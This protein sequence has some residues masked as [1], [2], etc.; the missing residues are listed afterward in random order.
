M[1]QKASP[2]LYAKLESLQDGETVDVNIFLLNKPVLEPAAENLADGGLPLDPVTAMQAA[3]SVNQR[4]LVSFLTGPQDDFVSLNENV[5]TPTAIVKDTYWI[6]N[7]VT[8]E[9]D[10]ET[11]EAI[12][13]REDVDYVELRSNARLQDMLDASMMDGGLSFDGDVSPANQASPPTA[14]TPQPSATIERIGAPLMWKEGLRGEGIIVAVIDSGVNYHHPDLKSHMWD[15]GDEFPNHGFDMVTSDNNPF[16]D[17]A[18]FNG[19]GTAC[20]GIIAGDGTSGE[21]TGVAPKATLMAIRIK[22]EETALKGLEQALEHHPHVISM[23]F[24]KKHVTLID[25]TP[26]PSETEPDSLKWRK[27]CESIFNAGIL[28]ANSAGNQG[29]SPFHK[30][31]RNIGSPPDCPPPKLHLLQSLKGGVSSVISCGAAT[32]NDSLDGWSSNG[33]VA[34]NSTP[35]SDY[36]F[37]DNGNRGLMKPD[38]CAPGPGSRSCN[39]RFNG[40]NGENPYRGFDFTSA[41]AA[42]LGGCLALLAQACLRSNNPIVPARIQQALEETA[43]FMKG[44][45]QRKEDNFGAGRINVH[46]AYLYGQKLGWWD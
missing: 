27:T 28:H 45:T 4:D 20:A 13:G 9:V 35:F 32:E 34:W 39:F 25:G 36:P 11:L 30:I 14:A 8:A 43:V 15:G 10:R 3:A 7:S 6:N 26:E 22:D 42:H 24:S 38:V 44:Q 12:L 41:A 37:D 29:N 17:D 33:P 16:D 19:H 18:D 46:E 2:A 1:A 5:S 21:A 40:S 23:S 31:P